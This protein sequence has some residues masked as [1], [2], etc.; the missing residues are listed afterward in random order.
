MIEIISDYKP[1]NADRIREMSDEELAELIHNICPFTE[2]G[3]PKLS[4]SWD[5]EYEV[6]DNI[7][8]ILEWLQQPS[9]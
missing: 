1:T 3:E 6:G 2:C 7:H 8:D 4:I 5:E 9:E